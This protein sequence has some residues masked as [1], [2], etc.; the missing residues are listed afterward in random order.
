M[1]NFYLQYCEQRQRKKDSVSSKHWIHQQCC[2]SNGNVWRE[3]ERDSLGYQ[4]IEAMAQ[5]RF[6]F[7]S[8]SQRIAKIKI[9][10]RRIGED[11]KQIP[12]EEQDTF[13]REALAKWTELNC[14]QD[15]VHFN[16]EVKGLV[17]NLRQLLFHKDEVLNIIYKHITIPK[18][19]CL[20]ALLDLFA[21]LARDLQYE[22]YPHFEQIFKILTNLLTSH[23][24]TII[25]KTFVCLAYVFKYLWRYMLDDAPKIYRYV[26][27]TAWFEARFESLQK[28]TK[29]PQIRYSTHPVWKVRHFSTRSQVSTKKI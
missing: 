20:D 6:K 7:Q 22:I 16:R 12:D 29:L 5:N 18:S 28:A 14:T 26:Y 17:Q 23:D 24:A 1:D 9:D 3:T 13:F 10:V 27:L 11:R 25:E 8:F 4:L 19:N 2:E 15:F 21:Q